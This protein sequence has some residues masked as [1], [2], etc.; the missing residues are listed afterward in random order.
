MIDPGETLCCLLDDFGVEAV[1]NGGPASLR[2]D[3]YPHGSAQYDGDALTRTGPYAVALAA[4]VAALELV[5][6]NTGDTLTIAGTA[7]TLLAI[8]PDG[9]GGVVLSLG[10]G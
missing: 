7:Y 5:S 2:V 1:V 3:W 6:G 4:D 10:V 8:D 9:L